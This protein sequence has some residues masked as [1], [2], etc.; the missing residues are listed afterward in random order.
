MKIFG[1]DM[2]VKYIRYELNGKKYLVQFKSNLIKGIYDVSVWDDDI[3][4]TD[5][6]IIL[7]YPPLKKTLAILWR[8]DLPLWIK[9]KRS[10][11]R[12]GVKEK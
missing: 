10:T 11:L 7:V 12:K 5:A 3:G 9:K 8:V 4:E 1:I 6:K 2:S